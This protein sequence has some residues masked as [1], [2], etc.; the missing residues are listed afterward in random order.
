MRSDIY[1]TKT[2]IGHQSKDSYRGKPMGTAWFRNDLTIPAN[3][4][5]RIDFMV[6]GKKNHL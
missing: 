2:P 4:K 5:T 6:A 1:E 3:A